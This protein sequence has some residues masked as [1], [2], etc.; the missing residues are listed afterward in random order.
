MLNVSSYV[1]IT[2]FLVALVPPLL[3]LK[4]FT[5][6]ISRSRYPDVISGSTVFLK[7][8][9]CI[10]YAWS[11]AFALAFL[12]SLPEYPAGIY[13]HLLPIISQLL[14]GLP[15]N[16]LIPN[17]YMR[18]SDE[19]IRFN[20]MS[21]AFAAMPFALNK[22]NAEGVAAV[23]QYNLTGREPETKHMVIKDGSCT[24][25][26]GT[27]DAPVITIN[28]DS[29]LWLK[30][31][32][33]DIDEA[34]AYMNGEYEVEGDVSFLRKFNSLFRSEHVQK[35]VLRQ[36]DYNYK[37]LGA[38][39]VEKVVIFDGGPR[40]KS[41]S[42]TTWMAHEFVSGCAAAGARIDIVKLVDFDIRDCSGCYA[43]W[44]K[45]PGKCI[46]QDSMAELMIKYRSADLVV[47]ASPLYIFSV[48]GIMK[49]FLDRLLPLLKPYLETDESGQ[50]Y[51]PDRYAEYGEQGFVV[52]S[53]SGFPNV[54]GNFDGLESMFRA[55]DSHNKNIHLLGEFFLPAA[56]VM[57]L[58]IYADRKKMVGDA[59]YEAGIQAVGN[60]EIDYRNMAK[61]AD[62]MVDEADF[63]HQAN[64]FW[65]MLDG[66]QSYR[67]LVPK[68]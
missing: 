26:A 27:A 61:V 38:G 58:P 32:N 18:R 20:S 66:K 25:L 3:R 11:L 33:R 51:H 14:I 22:K 55:W 64:I 54:K 16:I 15:A 47:F 19:Q 2:L 53:A 39:K 56:E 35:R 60:G 24:V 5:Y 68:L 34:K 42:K 13:A 45:T 62:I 41:Y 4:P 44:T 50:S 8:N 36:K 9:N 12:L 6:Y 7:I 30:I 65:G 17:I 48:T 31:I 28:A 57:S 43:C 21:E 46:H 63:R 49:T 67:K 23:V 10:S 40:E 1:Y 52:F 59:C 29:E 37:T